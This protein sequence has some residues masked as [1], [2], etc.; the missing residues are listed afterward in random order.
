[1]FLLQVLALFFA[2]QTQI[3]NTVPPNSS[4][5]AVVAI[6]ALLPVI[7]VEITKLGRRRRE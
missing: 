7:V 4:D 3:L 6:T 1:M 5:L 2:S